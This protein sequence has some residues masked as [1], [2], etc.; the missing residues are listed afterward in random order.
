M[1]F[2]H[3]NCF[4]GSSRVFNFKISLNSS[5]T[6]IFFSSTVLS[7]SWFCPFGKK[8]CDITYQLFLL[9]YFMLDAFIWFIM[10]YIYIYTVYRILFNP[11]LLVFLYLLRSC[12]VSLMNPVKK[13]SYVEWHCQCKDMFSMERPE[14]LALNKKT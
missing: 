5:K 12:S 9:L 7:Q 3:C 2:L 8:Y 4:P 13:H 1:F 14:R 11:G 6:R 10:Q